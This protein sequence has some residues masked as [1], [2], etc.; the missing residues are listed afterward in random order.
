MVIKEY[1]KN[2]IYHAERVSDGDIFITIKVEIFYDNIRLQ[3]IINT[4]QF[5]FLFF[6]IQ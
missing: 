1:I 5:F 4:Y 3:F 6:G 2:S